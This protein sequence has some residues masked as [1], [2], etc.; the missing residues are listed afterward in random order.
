MVLK[1]PVK[2]SIPEYPGSTEGRYGLGEDTGLFWGSDLI[3]RM[4]RKVSTREMKEKRTEEKHRA[5]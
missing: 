3:L 5:V 1:V 2:I 4:R